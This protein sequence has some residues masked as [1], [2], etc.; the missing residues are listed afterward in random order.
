M[1]FAQIYKSTF[2][3]CLLIALGCTPK[4]EPPSFQT[5]P[6]EVNFQGC[7]EANLAFNHLNPQDLRKLVTCLNGRNQAV[8]PFQN[9]VESISDEDL[10]VI[11][12]VYNSHFAGARL[13]QLIAQLD[14]FLRQ[15]NLK[16]FLK[17][18]GILIDSEVPQNLVPLLVAFIGRKSQTIS[19]SEQALYDFI[20]Q[21]LRAGEGPGLISSAAHMFGGT[22]GQV[23][24]YLL[25]HPQSGSLLSQDQV[26]DKLSDAFIEAYDDGKLHSALTHISD[27]KVLSS[28]QNASSQ[29]ITYLSTFVN[30]LASGAV[31]GKARRLDQ[32]GKLG[33]YSSK[34]LV[35]YR[36]SS[37]DLRIKENLFD[38]LVDEVSDLQTDQQLARFFLQTVP[39]LVAVSQSQCN[40]PQQVVDNMP[41]LYQAVVDGYGQ[42]LKA[43]LGLLE[44]SPRKDIILGALDS[45]MV[46]KLSPILEEVGRRQALPFLLES[47]LLT[48][49]AQDR[50][51]LARVLS[52]YTTPRIGSKNIGKWVKSIPEHTVM[53]RE[54]LVGKAQDQRTALALDL[55]LMNN[56]DLDN[57][58]KAH[59]EA[60]ASITWKKKDGGPYYPTFDRAVGYRIKKVLKR[61]RPLVKNFVNSLVR[62]WSIQGGGLGTLL[63]VLHSSSDQGVSALDQGIVGVLSDR[64]LMAKLVP[65]LVRVSE[66]PTLN[67]AIDYAGTLATNGKLEKLFLFMVDLLKASQGLD[68]D[69]SPLPGKVSVMTANVSEIIEGRQSFAPQYLEGYE[70]CSKIS[71]NMF[72]PPGDQLLLLGQCLNSRGEAPA[73]VAFFDRLGVKG[74]DSLSSIIKAG[75]IDSPFTGGALNQLEDLSKSGNLDKLLELL[76]IADSSEYDFP[77]KLVPILNTVVASRKFPDVLHW[78]GKVVSAPSFNPSMGALLK[79]LGGSGEKSYFSFNNF[80]FNLNQYNWLYREAHSQIKNQFPD[81]SAKWIS[82]QFK[83]AV[84]EFE[85]HNDDWFCHPGPYHRDFCNPETSR[86]YV[87]GQLMQFFEKMLRGDTTLM[88]VRALQTISQ[89]FNVPDLLRKGLVQRVAIY[90]KPNGGPRIRIMTFFDQFET[91]VENAQIQLASKLPVIG[92]DHVAMKFM[93]DVANSEDLRATMNTLNWQ[94]DLGEDWAQIY[95]NRARY[96]NVRNMISNYGVLHAWADNP[97]MGL[98]QVL[99]K[100]MLAA[101][102]EEYRKVQDPEK[103]Y[104]GNL[105]HLNNIG[106]FAALS[107]GVASAD[108]QSTKDNDV[109]ESIVNG[110]LGAVNLLGPND[111]EPLQEVVAALV[112]KSNG[113]APLEYIID[114]VYYLRD[115][116]P[117]AYKNLKETLLHFI[118]VAHLMNRDITEITGLIKGLPPVI[119]DP[120]VFRKVL[121]KF[122]EEATLD[123]NLL[124]QFAINLSNVEMETREEVNKLVNTMFAIGPETAGDVF[125]AVLEVSSQAFA[126]HSERFES[127]QESFK[128][129]VNDPKVKD[130]DAVKT[131]R[132][133]LTEMSAYKGINE[134]VGFVTSDPHLRKSLAMLFVMAD[135]GK[136][137]DDVWVLFIEKVKSGQF[138]EAL[139]FI[140]EHLK[141]PTI[142]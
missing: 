55:Q 87:K 33:A 59:K 139:H 12:E 51:T 115:Q 63:S 135:L 126:D 47:L 76:V 136:S 116:K 54:L 53:L 134:S 112:D 46:H 48:Q 66:L 8:Q 16:A 62:S 11:L 96:N 52:R 57:T 105:I 123:E 82:N 130:L 65:I 50:S 18:T 137:M 64:A 138:K 125:P 140:F 84:E 56:V 14:T 31:H 10:S 81:R 113:Q 27:I 75:L 102:P 3:A 132:A 107:E 78:I 19:S 9:L 142:H 120:V 111:I 131:L 92:A 128:H 17:S 71:T 4:V 141:R 30:Y 121:D 133:A 79:T 77:R 39:L 97:T 101:T 34:P 74:R 5:P 110:I 119:Q 60:I 93:F 6:M 45:P 42:G 124:L 44:N 40:Y 7:R 61:K 20:A 109:L 37:K 108:R 103:N 35:C 38:L 88:T 100:H 91:L 15:D 25:S 43:L 118:P 36:N 89:Q 72:D 2:L 86:E 80:R 122:I 22:Q 94:I 29:Q 69:R 117:E 41:V 23:L 32:M 106:F 1:K 24:A 70:S 21:T 67:P 13:D 98:L 85:T 99:F 73:L 90:Y 58:L 49:T 68:H 114:M 129:F 104:L 28:A 83:R 26:I 95:G 127:I